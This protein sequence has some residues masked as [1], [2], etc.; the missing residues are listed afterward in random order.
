MRSYVMRFFAVL[1][2][3]TSL[4]LATT[5]YSPPLPDPLPKGKH[6][7]SFGNSPEGFARRVYLSKNQFKKFLDEGQVYHGLP[8]ELRERLESTRF[9]IIQVA[10]GAEIST[11]V[12]CG[13]A[14]TDRKK[15]IYFWNLAAPEFL[16]IS[17]EQG[18]SCI[19]YLSPSP[20][21]RDQPPETVG[22]DTGD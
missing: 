10:D 3:T 17:D 2:L 21:R 15:R 12:V 9:G 19:I 8:D 5:R 18:R 4:A 22:S 16:G 6:V 13:G 20:L 14:F 1:F 11:A 7:V